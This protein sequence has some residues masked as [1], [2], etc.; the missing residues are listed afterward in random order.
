MFQISSALV[1]FQIRRYRS[2]MEKNKSP[3]LALVSLIIQIH[4]LTAMKRISRVQNARL[5]FFFSK[6]IHG[7]MMARITTMGNIELMG[8]LQLLDPIYDRYPAYPIKTN[9]ATL[10]TI[11]ACSDGPQVSSS[12]SLN[13]SSV[14]AKL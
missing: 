13:V 10:I 2:Q 11:K 3:I 14:V 8:S 7:Y 4:Q 9:I 1:K 12:N 6:R 5:V